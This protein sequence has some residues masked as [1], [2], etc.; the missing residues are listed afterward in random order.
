MKKK[1]FRYC[2]SI[3]YKISGIMQENS[4]YELIEDGFLDRARV[5]LEEAIKFLEKYGTKNE[6]INYPNEYED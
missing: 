6:L 1:E 5:G 3:L 2:R 4:R